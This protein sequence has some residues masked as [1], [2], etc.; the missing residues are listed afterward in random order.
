M[1]LTNEMKRAEAAYFLGAQ[2]EYERGEEVANLKDEW[3]RNW[4][5]TEEA[6]ADTLWEAFN[7][8]PITTAMASAY[9]TDDKDRLNYLI[10]KAISNHMKVL[11]AIAY[12]E[13]MT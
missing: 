13:R 12:D 2:D 5:E 4:L 3:I 7:E 11:A 10:R 6:T 8:Q 9:N 1:S